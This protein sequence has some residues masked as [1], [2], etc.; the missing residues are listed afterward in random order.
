MA[1][2]GTSGKSANVVAVSKPQRK[3]D[4][5]N[6]AWKKANVGSKLLSKMGGWQEGQ[7]IGK[8]QRQRDEVSDGQGLRV[9]KRPDGWGIGH[10]STAT[11][12][13]AAAALPHVNDFTNVLAS[14]R[15]QHQP[16]GPVDKDDDVNE[17]SCT[18]SAEQQRP[19]KKKRLSTNEPRSKTRSKS[20][21]KTKSSTK[22]N[23]G[24]SSTAVLPRN[25]MTHAKVRAAKFQ[26]KSDEDW[27]G[28]FGTVAT[29]ASRGGSVTTANG[30]L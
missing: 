16:Q 26:P 10:D 19:R 14:L 24:G 6:L 12:A 23:N 21:K 5:R 8:R 13:A 22:T 4:V 2:D 27:V 1:D 20:S 18:N 15:R 11:N 3:P 17:S 7:A 29:A 25:R 28:I 30:P 9:M